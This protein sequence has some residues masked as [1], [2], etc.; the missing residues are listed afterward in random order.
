MQARLVDHL[1]CPLCVGELSLIIAETVGDEVETGTLQCA[2]CGASFPIERGIPRLAPSELSTEQRRTAVAFGWS[3]QHFSE[4]TAR[5][6]EQFLDWIAPLGSPDFRDRL[7]LDAGCGIG[8]N[9]YFAAMYGARDVIAMDLS[10][11]VEVAK[12]V[13]AEFPNAHVVQGDLLRPPFRR[14]PGTFDLVYSIGVIHHLPDPPAGIRSLGRVLAPDG[15]LAVWV[16]GYEN[17]RFVRHW[18]EPLR[19]VST[20]LNPSVMRGLAWPL[21]VAFHGA[22]RGVYRPL[23]GTRVGDKLPLHEYLSSLA[24]FGF[25]ENYQIVFD[26]LVAP[27]AVYVKRDELQSWLE[28]AGLEHVTLTSSREMSWR[29]RGRAPASQLVRS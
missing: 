1:V 24:G 26:Q 10:D 11:A 17:N 4:M 12:D 25:R 19:R 2:D 9:A 23:S 20:K 16:Y 13:L 6:E 27:T 8:R 29:G 5:S 14:D 3:W 21:A 15:T 7:V 28:A 18:V 22:V